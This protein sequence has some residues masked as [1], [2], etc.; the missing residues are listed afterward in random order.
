[1]GS[2]R[3]ALGQLRLGSRTAAGELGVHRTD[4]PLRGGGAAPPHGVRSLDAPDPDATPVAQ[5]RDSDLA[6]QAVASQREALDVIPAQEDRA[7]RVDD[8]HAAVLDREAR[9]SA[10]GEQREWRAERCEDRDA[11]QRVTRAGED[12]HLN[13]EAE[14]QATGA[15]AAENC[16]VGVFAAHMW[17]S[18]GVLDEELKLRLPDLATSTHRATQ[19]ET[20]RRPLARSPLMLRQNVGRARVPGSGDQIAWTLTAFGPLSPASAS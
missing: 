15:K 14:R 16:A 20:Q 2:A 11:R 6:Q 8:P 10:D 12:D 1:M 18:I 17:S 3:G 9:K 19:A 5:F 7:T 13:H 4:E